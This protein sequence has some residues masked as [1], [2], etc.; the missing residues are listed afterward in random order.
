MPVL[1]PVFLCPFIHVHVALFRDGQLLA[2]IILVSPDV[3]PGPAEL[4]FCY[5]CSRCLDDV[6][7]LGQRVTCP[8]FEA[9]VEG[10]LSVACNCD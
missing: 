3:F 4:C 2:H 1:L 5:S 8:W 9:P 7:V 10:A 6:K